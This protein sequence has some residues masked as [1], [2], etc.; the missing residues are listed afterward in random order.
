MK[1]EHNDVLQALVAA[2]MFSEDIGLAAMDRDEHGG[3]LHPGAG[4]TVLMSETARE[5][6]AEAQKVIKEH[7]NGWGLQQ[8][9]GH[10]YSRYDLRE[11]IPA[12]GAT[13]SKTVMEFDFDRSPLSVSTFDGEERTGNGAEALSSFADT[14]RSVG[15]EAEVR[16][17]ST[18]DVA[19]LVVRG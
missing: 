13:A 16:R 6:L 3:Q 2:L 9:E 11:A 19:T 5:L 8:D 7:D 10:G 18:W 14:L 17:G 1:Y 15:M 12:E 4:N